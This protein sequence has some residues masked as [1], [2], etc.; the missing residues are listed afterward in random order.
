MFAGHLGSYIRCVYN[1]QPIHRS[2]PRIHF[3]REEI[4]DKVENWKTLHVH[5][6]HNFIVNIPLDADKKQ[7]YKTIVMK[8]FT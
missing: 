6:L 7:G 8:P 4:E 1:A 2:L 3:L 5:F